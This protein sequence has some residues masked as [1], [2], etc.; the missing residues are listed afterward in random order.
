MKSYLKKAL[1]SA[2]IR[3][4]LSLLLILITL[5]LFIGG[6]GGGGS[7]DTASADGSGVITGTG[8]VGRAAT[9]AAIADAEVTIK[10][11]TGTTVTT[12][13]DRHGGFGSPEITEDSANTPRGPF[14]LRIVLSNGSYLYS[15]AHVENAVTID[16]DS[17]EITVNIHPFTDLV[18]RNWF[19]MQGLDIDNAFAG[20]A[21][22]SLPSATEIEAISNEFLGILSEALNAN[23]VSDVN[24]LLASPFVIGDEFDSFLDNSTVIINNQINIFINQAAG[25]DSIQTTLVGNVDLDYD[26]TNASDSAPTIPQNLRA[27]PASDSEVVIVWEPS[28][29]DKGVAGYHVYRDAVLIATTPFPVYTD[30]GLSTGISYSYTV[31]AFDGRQQASGQPATAATITLDTP[32]TTPPPMATSVQASEAS[33]AIRLSWTISDIGDVEGFRIYRGASGRVDTSGNPLAVITVTDFHDFDVTAGTTYCYRIITFDAADNVSEPTPESCATMSGTS[34]PSTVSFS[35]ASYRIDE[36]QSS[37]TVTVER[38]GDLSEAISVDYSVSALSATAG[39]D[40]T[41]ISGTLNWGATDSSAKSFSVQIAQDN[42]TESDETVQLTLSNPVATSLGGNDTATLTI[43]DALQV[44]CIEL[45]PTD[46]TTDTTL[47]EPCYN[48]TSDVSVSD[49]ATLTI[50]SGVRLVFSAEARLSIEEDGLLL[51]VGTQSEP[52]TFTSVLQAAGYWDGIYID[53]IATSML[54]HVVVEYAGGT[55][56]SDAANLTLNSGGNLSVNN[57][58]LRYSGGYGFSASNRSN[59]E[60]SSFSGNTVT[61]NENAPLYIPADMIGDL[62]VN[63]SFT[64]NVTVT[65]G[66]NDY[67]QVV[68]A[69][70]GDDITRDQTWHNHGIDYRMPSNRTEIGAV[71]TLS[72]GVTLVFQADSMLEIETEGTLN[73]VGTNGEPITFTG[74]QATPGF[75]NGIQFYYNHTN[76]IME[77]TIVE[78]GGGDADSHANVHVLGRDGMLT[79]RNSILRHSEGNGFNFDI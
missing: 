6:C 33:N 16:N 49:N 32:D 50:E 54:E 13:T 27:L 11:S 20:G 71:L 36:A 28:S 26:F 38:S 35:N 51:A 48:M 59:T 57:S 34:T 47:S 24:D 15:I 40:F 18:I 2:G 39:V 46:I 8:I 67:I 75:W 72:P 78:Y 62:D 30:S 74:L 12:T 69:Q 43:S 61:L 22:D 56:D 1:F 60:I 63:N 76:N 17:E 4:V 37:V 14:L 45:S 21:L 66:D 31:E 29:D 5:M 3:S 10:S 19:A 9:G 65:G 64:G 52:I 55:T 23:S 77:H 7:E 42:E 41:E 53:S 25:T 79:I 73:A 44:S 58:T 70:S 68:A